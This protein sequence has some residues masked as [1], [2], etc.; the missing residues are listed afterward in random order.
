MTKNPPTTTKTCPSS[1]LP[2]SFPSYSLPRPPFVYQCE[3]KHWRHSHPTFMEAVMRST[4]PPLPPIAPHDPPAPPCLTPAC[5]S[6]TLV[7]SCPPIT[8]LSLLPPP[9]M[10]PLLTP[11][12]PPPSPPPESRP[13]VWV[14]GARVTSRVLGGV[15]LGVQL[16]L[17]GKR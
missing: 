6:D 17:P 2:S 15:N 4:L 7:P 8:P 13:D 11:P 3:F 10:S 14:V 9:P 16:S 1:Y 5:P 12:A